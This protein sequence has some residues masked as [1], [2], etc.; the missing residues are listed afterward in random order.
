MMSNADQFY[1]A[2]I[3]NQ[4]TRAVGEAEFRCETSSPCTL[5]CPPAG[6][7]RVPQKDPDVKFATVPSVPH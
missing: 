3:P 5:Y 4:K 6:G 2:T 7:D 1:V